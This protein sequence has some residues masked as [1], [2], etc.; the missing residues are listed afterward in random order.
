MLPASDSVNV[1]ASFD[2]DVDVDVTVAIFFWPKPERSQ[3]LAS[4]LQA[5]AHMC[6]HVQPYPNEV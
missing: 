3:S 6:N 5:A 4:Y 2:V 1:N